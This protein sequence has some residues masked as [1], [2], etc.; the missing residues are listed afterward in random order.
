LIRAYIINFLDSDQG[1]VDKAE[2][3]PRI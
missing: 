1:R 2:A 3:Q